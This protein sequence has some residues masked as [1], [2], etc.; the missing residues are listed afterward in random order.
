MTFLPLLFAC[1]NSKST[2]NSI[3]C[4]DDTL[5]FYPIDLDTEPRNR[6]SPYHNEGPQ[7]AAFDVD[8]DGAIEILQCFMDEPL[9]QYG[10]SN[11][12]IIAH[13]C[14]AL[15]I[16]DWNNDGWDDLVMEVQANGLRRQT[17][18]WW[19]ENQQG[20]LVKSHDT[21]FGIDQI[22]AMRVAD[23]NLDGLPDI[24]MA[25]LGEMNE[26]SDANKILWGHDNYQIDDPLDPIFNARKTFDSV[27]ADFNNDGWPDVMD[28]N[29]R[30]PE[31]GGNVLWLNNQGRL[32]PV[33]DCDCLPIQSAKGLDAADINLDGWI[34]AVSADTTQTYLIQNDGAGGFVDVSTAWGA[35]QLE[36]Q[37]MSWG[38]RLLDVN[39]DGGIDILSAIGDH[40]FPGLETPEYEGE[41]PF[42]VL[43]QTPAGFIE[44]SSKWGLDLMGSFR[45][46]IPLHWNDDGILD[47]WITDV[48][49]APTLMVSN[50]CSDGNWLSFTGMNGTKIKVHAR[51]RT[52]TGSLYGQSSYGANRS[53]LWHIGLGGIQTVQ[54]IEIQ[55]P[56]E[57]W[58]TWQE[59]IPVNQHLH[60][61]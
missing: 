15:A 41:L 54:Q 42:S 37:E 6:F 38:V 9:I 30:G 39:N 50:G 16:L 23:I 28:A 19:F 13:K 34:D 22:H 2:D 55:R 18:L 57:T 51:N 58:S 24:Y 17:K 29:D 52:W 8:Q 11:Q 40:T 36:P 1:T 27:I 46:I 32:E 31:F 7:V 33:E 61:P 3:Q 43:K 10:R 45:S 47:Y 14:G 21:T 5:Y 35:A 49:Q 56:G 25:V 4:T 59:S 12:A 60:I 44:T 48:E 53:P 20:H 26:Q